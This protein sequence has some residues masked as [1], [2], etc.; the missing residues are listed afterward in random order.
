ME[1]IDLMDMSNGEILIE[2]HNYLHNKNYKLSTVNS[3]TYAVKIVAER[4]NYTFFSD[5]TVDVEID[6]I[7][8]KYDRNGA[9]EQF[10]NSGKRTVI[11]A[12]KRFR[13][14]IY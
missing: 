12:L 14:F 2:Y 10:G 7:I 5:L 1:K 6:A 4:E 3:Y 11:N 9:E 8:K 13:E